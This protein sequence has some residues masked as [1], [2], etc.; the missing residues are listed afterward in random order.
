[1]SKETVFDF[2][3]DF[4]IKMMGRNTPEFRMTAVSIIEAHTG[5]VDDKKIQ[6]SLSR[7]GRFVSITISI[8]AQSQRQL[9]DIYEDVSA[10]DD[11]LMAL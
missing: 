8:S 10:H 1:M 11:V 3:C 2:P 6:S 7:N 4:P 5:T 9:D